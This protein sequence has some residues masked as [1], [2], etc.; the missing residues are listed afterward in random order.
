M[1]S[2]RHLRGAG[3]EAAVGGQQVGGDLDIGRGRVGHCETMAAM[4]RISQRIADVA[5]SATLAIDAKAKALVGG[6]RG[7]HRRS[8][9][10]SPTSRPRPTSWPPPRTACS[11]PRNHKYTPAAG[12]PELEA[13]VATKTGTRFRLRRW[14]P[15]R[16]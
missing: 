10:A 4:A 6:G 3:P 13:A 12:L 7:R 1:A 9:P 5:E 16:C 2:G 14:R 8:V 11:D 15:P